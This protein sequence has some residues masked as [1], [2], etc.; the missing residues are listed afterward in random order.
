MCKENS[1]VGGSQRLLQGF[2]LSSLGYECALGLTVGNMIFN[3]VQFLTYGQMKQIIG[4]GEILTLPQ[5][6]LAGAFTGVAVSFVETPMDL[7]KSQLQVQI[8]RAKDNP[9]YKAEFNTVGGAIKKI[10][11]VNGIFGCYQGFCTTLLRD[12]IAVSLYFG[13]YEWYRRALLKKDQPLSDM[14]YQG[15]FTQ[16]MAGGVGG[17]AYWAGIYPLDIVKSQLQVDNI[18]KA[19]RKYHGFMDCAKRLYAEGGVKAFFPGF[20]PCIIRAFLGN[21]ACFVCYEQSKAMMNKVF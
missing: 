18:V 9:E 2:Y 19:E 8:I 6:F 15:M 16:F 21:A 4:H 10:I 12:T 20:T 1:E 17:I 14:Q 3:A 13:V 11:K 7:F 5:T